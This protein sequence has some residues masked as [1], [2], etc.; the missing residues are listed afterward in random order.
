M[1]KACVTG[2]GGFIGS[3]VVEEL[4]KTGYEVECLV[5]YTSS[6]SIGCLAEVDKKIRDKIK[7]TYGDITDFNSML[8]LT[9]GKD[10]VFHLAAL[11]SI[12]YSYEN[13]F[14]YIQANIIG[15]YNILM[16]SKMN[17]V[18]KIVQTS[19]SEVYGTAQYAPIDEKH[20]MQGQSPYSA[21]K[22]GADYLAESFFKSFDVPVAIIRPFNCYGPRQSTR[23]IIPTIITQVL[24]SDK[25]KVGS[26]TPTR[27]FT[28]VK[29]TARAF[30]E[31]A[32]SDKTIGEVINIGNGQEI[33][34]KNLIDEVQSI[35]GTDLPVVSED[36]RMRPSK[37]EVFR[38]IAG[39]DKAKKL[40][41]WNTEYNLK[42]G[43]DETIKY[44]KN[45]EVS[46]DYRT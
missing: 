20:P 2:A 25:I 41:G 21:T 19:T 14:S 45:R 15:S 26:L 34:V 31:I 5:R 3:H 39:I 17:K 4:V 30:R 16:A 9:R 23:A 36:A 33:S 46:L 40:I 32:E 13:P 11:I 6:G 28:Y 43:L 38:L 1:K 12:P 35:L 27:D 29:D 42:K 18:S 37:S 44:F 10:C 24:N 8:N 22:I 7:I